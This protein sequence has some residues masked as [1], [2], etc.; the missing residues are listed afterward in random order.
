[1]TQRPFVPRVALIASL[2]TFAL[3]AIPAFSQTSV[4]TQHND[5]ARSGA[6]SNE[7]V[8]TTANVAGGNFGKLFT[9]TLDDNVNGQVL[10][11]PHL[12]INGAL[13]NTIIAYTSNGNNSSCS[14]YAFDA[15]DPAQTTPLWRHQFTNSAQWTTSTPAIDIATNTIYVLTKDTNDSG[16]TRLRALDLLTGAE[17]A[18][19]PVTIAATVNGTGD[20]SSGGHVSFDTT[21][22]NCRPGLLF[23]NNSVYI[24]IA[25]N[26]D[27]FPYH[28]WVFRYTYNGAAFTQANVFCVNPNG[29]DDGIW[30]AGNGLAT[31]SS[32]NV[33]A[34]TG[35]GTFDVNA[36]GVDYG[37]SVLKLSPTLSVLDYFTP[38]DESG[39][40]NADLDFGNCGVMFVPGTNRLFTGG[41]K[42]GGSCFLLDSTN[43]GH[44]TS[45][46]PDNI[47]N[48]ID[49]LSSDSNVGQNPVGWDSGTFK[50]TY[51]WARSAGINQ[52]R[53]DPGVGKLSPNAVF[54]TNSGL[55]AGGSLA[56]SSNGTANG[57]LWAV[58][59]SVVHAIP[60]TAVNQ[61]DLW[62]SSAN[63]ARDGLPS[64]GHW[65]FPTV[66]N[67]RVYVPTGS[68]SIV[69]YGLLSTTATP[70][71]TPPSGIIDASQSIT[72]TDST[73]G[74]SIYYTVDGTTPYPG[75]GSTTLYSGGFTLSGSSTVTAI[76]L[77]AN[78]EPSAIASQS[79][80]VQVAS[81]TISPDAGTYTTS[82][83]ITLADA[84]SG[85]SIYYTTDG[86]TPTPGSGTTVRYT[87][88][89]TLTKN[90]AVSAMARIDGTSNVSGVVTSSFKVKAAKPTFSPLP[91][92]ITS[93]TSVTLSDAT[94]GASMYYTLDGSAPN[95]GTGTTQHY[96]APITVQPGTTVTV[97]ATLSG[98]TRS[99]TAVGVYGRPLAA[100]P[101]I[102]PHGG[103]HVTS[104]TITITDTTTGAS[105]FYTTDGTAPTPGAGTTVHYTAPF[106]IAA[107]GPVKA[108]ATAS[109]FD[110]SAVATETFTI[111]TSKPGVTPNG[112]TPIYP[113]SVT[114]NDNTPGATIYYT[115]DGSTPT[116]GGGGSTQTYAGAFTLNGPATVTSIAAAPGQ[117]PSAISVVTFH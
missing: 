37:M 43:M 28:G 56:V 19:S 83:D 101:S 34:T 12:T 60:A 80:D 15:D 45:G 117:T 65:Q 59:G 22:A 79:Y 88:P 9:R 98:G 53:Y 93:P 46:G 47:L 8:L 97:I 40:S 18:G 113:A 57:I 2:L 58:G 26:S 103:T 107:S 71:I 74:A 52:F 67:G 55:T 69:A 64:T 16:P 92:P 99:T 96:H 82:V 70:Q 102:S 1:M 91:G 112:G 7:V 76:A 86:S 75:Q 44:F 14:L 35:N 33:Y 6:N 29:G 23:A 81:P 89:F 27:S 11:V 63:S 90:A 108:V 84:T 114:I 68:S 21:H 61:A 41:T 13:H 100:T 5:N 62:N 85:A 38:F 95:P 87:A 106:T 30:M 20:G 3:C 25:H 31:D 49:H 72:I 10:Y 32:G 17:K 50:Y 4:L 94:P 73:P 36:G 54:L 104:S 111:Q 115:T 116:V 51:V 78:A 66:A 109:G 24:G 42:F 39:N 77:S 110:Q 48:R 105:I